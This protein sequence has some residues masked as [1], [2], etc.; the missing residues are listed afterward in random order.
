MDVF[1]LK[2]SV[3]GSMT[4]EEFLKFCLENPDLRI[5]RNSNLE[6]VI[7]SPVTT[8]SGNHSGEIFR[9]L[10]NWAMINKKGLAFDSS[11][12]FT[13]PDRSVLSPDAA[14][15]SNEKWDSLSEEDK[16]KFAPVCPEFVIE[17]RSKSDYHE[18]L[19]QKMRVWLKNGA[20]LGW[21][22][23]PREKISFIFRPGKEEEEIKG[24]NQKIAGEGPIT[25]FE[26]DLSL[27]KI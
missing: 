10:S 13:L 21:L 1:V 24:I 26:L 20:V 22:I 19:K 6:V 3:T 8:K 9:Q 17:V 15:V 14:W 25:G 11:A 23:D 5:E 16:D 4:D 27:L 12:G 2:D 18:D 7:M